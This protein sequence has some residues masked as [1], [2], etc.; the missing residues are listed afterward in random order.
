MLLAAGGLAFLNY[1]LVTT[2]I[3]V[4]PIPVDRAAGSVRL[5]PEGDGRKM[6]L[7]R[8][9]TDY[10][11]TL[12]RPLFNPTRRPLPPVQSTRPDTQ[13]PKAK[14]RISADQLEPIGIVLRAQDRRVLIRSP[15]TPIATWHSE[16]DVIAGWR[17]I[18]IRS[19]SVLVEADGSRRQIRLYADA[20]RDDAM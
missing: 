16:G 17:V 20:P 4:T 3:A 12:A 14:P 13:K 11:E 15:E 7:A 1:D 2:P 19:N 8:P 9:I 5:E 18:E 6:P 10:S